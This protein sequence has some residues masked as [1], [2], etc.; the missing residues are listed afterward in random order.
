MDWTGLDWRCGAKN[1]RHPLHP[2]SPLPVL[3]CTRTVGYLGT[4]TTVSCCTLCIVPYRPRGELLTRRGSHPP[5]AASS[6]TR[7]RQVRRD[8]W[9]GRRHYRQ[10]SAYVLP[11]YSVGTAQDRTG[12]TG[13]TGPRPSTVFRERL[14]ASCFCLLMRGNGGPA[15]RDRRGQRR[16][17]GFGGA[18]QSVV[19]RGRAW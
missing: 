6:P 4:V 2:S 9:F 17:V 7:Y 10:E 8:P 11:L 15:G 12:R 5:A 3:Y 16:F 14:F 19:K 1:Q 13:R 18:W